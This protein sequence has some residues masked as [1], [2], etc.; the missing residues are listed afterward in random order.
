ML[1]NISGKIE[2]LMVADNFFNI[3]I[4]NIMPYSKEP[5]QLTSITDS[6]ET[7]NRIILIAFSF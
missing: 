4:A 3:Q 1:E 7:I 2:N 5:Y 6:I